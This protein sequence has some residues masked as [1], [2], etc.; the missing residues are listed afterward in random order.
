MFLLLL[1]HEWAAPDFSSTDSSSLLCRCGRCDDDLDGGGDSNASSLLVEMPDE[2]CCA[3]GDARAA[4]RVAEADVTTR[5][6]KSMAT[7]TF[8]A[9]VDVEDDI[10][11]GAC[12]R[13]H[14]TS[15][16]SSSQNSPVFFSGR[17]LH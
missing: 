14:S 1:P 10:F 7:I 11:S 16:R 13:A 12:S 4:A 5:T 6:T 8:F 15:Q 3:P 2:A 17:L 9:I